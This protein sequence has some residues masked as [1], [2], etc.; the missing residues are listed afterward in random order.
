MPFLF[1]NFNLIAV[2]PYIGEWIEIDNVVP[3]PITLNVS[4]YIGEWIEIY[5]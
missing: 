4:P 1:C 3:F 5:Y 2:S